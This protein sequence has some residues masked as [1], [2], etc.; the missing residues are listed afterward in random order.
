MR[1]SNFQIAVPFLK[2]EQWHSRIRHGLSQ[3]MRVR[4]NAKNHLQARATRRM[5]R[6]SDTSL[7]I[8]QSSEMPEC[9]PPNFPRP[10]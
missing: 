6:T 2:V 8:G 5:T 3:P 4:K 7:T 1:L 10:R 9:C